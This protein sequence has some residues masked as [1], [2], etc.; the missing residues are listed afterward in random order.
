MIPRLNGFELL[1]A[2]YTM[3]HLKLDLLLSETGYAPSADQRFKIYLTNSLEEHHPDTGTLFAGWLSREANEAN[4]IKRDTPV[5]CVIGNPPYSGESAN[6]GKWIM[7]LMDDYKKEPGGKEKLKERNPKWINADE[8]KFIRFGQYFIEKNGEGVLAYINPH[9]FLDNPTFRGVRWNL[10]KTF[11]KIYTIDLHGNSKKKETAPDGSIDQNVFDIQQG[12]SINLFVKTGKKKAGEL[13]KVFHFDLYGKRELKYDFLWENNLETIDFTEL[14][15]VEP[16]FFFVQKD[17]DVEETYGTGFSLTELYLKDSMGITSGNDEVFISF[18]S[19]EL[20]SRFDENQFISAVSYRPFDHRSL[21]Y[22]PELLARARFDFMHHLRNQNNLSISLI[23]RSRSEQ[24]VSPLITESLVDKCIIST[25]DNANIFPLYLYPETG[26][27]Q[28]LLETTARTPNLNEEI[29]EEIAARLGLRF[30]SEKEETTPSTTTPSTTT[31]STEAV[32]TP[33]LEG[34]ELEELNLEEL[35]LEELN[36]EELNL[37]ELDLEGELETPKSSPPSKGGVSEG[38]GGFLTSS[39]YE[40]KEKINNLPYLK[41]FRK[42]LRNNLTPAEAKFWKFVQ[43]K[44]LAGRKFRRQHSVGN[45]ILDFYCPSEKLA[46]EL[47]GEVHFGDAARVYDYERRLFLEHYGIKVLRFE[48]KL[49]FEELAWVL[50]VIKSNFGWGER[51]M[52][53]EGEKQPP[54]QRSVATPPSKGGEPEFGNS[55]NLDSEH[56]DKSRIQKTQ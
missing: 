27:Q 17:F 51:E 3:A 5:M 13:A 47:D 54:R 6:K 24:I 28:N 39:T 34:G 12:V 42:T 31:P 55:T 10:L 48:N 46:I 14:K 2:S 52:K 36:L 23:R 37:E 25:L 45:Y 18:S 21:Y 50:D 26:D 40:S 29:V 1:M 30:V 22:K 11:D 4:H 53:I 7:D 49:V 43:N 35:N 8:Y 44:N 41:T 20:E 9:S 56:L 19:N 33:P 38:Q 15:S 16:N 32:D